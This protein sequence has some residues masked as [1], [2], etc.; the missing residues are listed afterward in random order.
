[1]TG[2][3]TFADVGIRLPTEQPGKHRLPC[4]RCDKGKADDALQITVTPRRWAF[5]KCWRCGW[6]DKAPLDDCPIEYQP[7]ARREP[8]TP[9]STRQGFHAGARRRW[10]TRRGI[11]GLGQKLRAAE[12]TP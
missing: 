4:P 1:M 5:W 9:K 6:E 12:V 8:T 2:S 11:T 3:A 7:P 10:E